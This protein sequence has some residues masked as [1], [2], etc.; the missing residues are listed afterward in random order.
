TDGAE[1]LFAREGTAIALD[2]AA[3][4]DGIAAGLDERFAARPEL[5]EAAR[6]SLAR[7]LV[8]AGEPRQARR[9][10]GTSDGRA[11]AQLRA[12]A[13]LIEGDAAAAESLARVLLVGDGRDGRSLTLMALIA[14]RAGDRAAAVGWLRRALDADPYDVEA[15]GLAAE[16]VGAATDASADHGRT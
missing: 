9:V 10:L 12:R 11:A 13:W 1:A 4:V 7:L 3:V 15:R 5:R 8:V 2:D 6:L 16:L 14:A